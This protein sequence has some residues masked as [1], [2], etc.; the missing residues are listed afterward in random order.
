MKLEA[1]NAELQ[2]ELARVK[3]EARNAELTTDALTKRNAEA[4]AQLCKERQLL[5]AEAEAKIEAITQSKD[6]KIEDMQVEIDKRGYMKHEMRTLVQE[7]QAQAREAQRAL[8][9]R[10]QAHMPPTPPKPGPGPRPR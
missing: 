8:A 2:A 1:R 9:Q 10:R 4:E 5:R 7:A 6:A 3:L